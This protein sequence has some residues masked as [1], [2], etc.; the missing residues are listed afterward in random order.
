ME[1]ESLISQA[2]AESKYKDGTFLMTVDAQGQEVAVGMYPITNGDEGMTADLVHP[3]F[4]KLYPIE[5]FEGEALAAKAFTAPQHRIA[6]RMGLPPEKFEDTFG[7][8]LGLF[9]LLGLSQAIRCEISG[10]RPGDIHVPDG[11][12]VQYRPATHASVDLLER[13]HDIAIMMHGRVYPS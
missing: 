7:L 9:L 3:L 12:T 8:K 4:F 1:Q 10:T 6:G 11:T 5:Q 2:E 13:A